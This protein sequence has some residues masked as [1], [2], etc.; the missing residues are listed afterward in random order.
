MKKYNFFT[1][2]ENLDKIG[3]DQEEKLKKEAL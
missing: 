2:C 1:F 3:K